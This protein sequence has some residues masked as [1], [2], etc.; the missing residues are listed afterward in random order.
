M[1]AQAEAVNGQGLCARG[2][3]SVK[4]AALSTEATTPALISQGLGYGSVIG[5][6][7]GA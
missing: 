7:A 1:M 2:E 5:T 6:V 3:V 4:E